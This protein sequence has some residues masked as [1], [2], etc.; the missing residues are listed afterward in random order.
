LVSK[1]RSLHQTQGGSAGNLRYYHR[2]PSPGLLE[3]G[4]LTVSGVAARLGVTTNTL[5]YWIT[6]GWL[7]ARR[8][9]DGRYAIAF[10]DQVEA[11]CRTRIAGSR[12][13]PHQN[14]DAPA[15]RGDELTVNQVA[16]RLQIYTNVVYYWL[17]RGYLDAR[18]DPTGGWCIP[19]PVEV[20]AACRQRIAASSRIVPKPRDN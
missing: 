18:R 15:R 16:H 11:N 5:H 1:A 9:H 4:E 12:H 3:P 7:P 10:T 14:S 6:R 19:F 20:E 2:I 17:Q 8:C 13:L